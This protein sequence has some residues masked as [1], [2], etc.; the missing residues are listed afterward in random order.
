MNGSEAPAGEATSRRTDADRQFYMCWSSRN[1]DFRRSRSFAM[2]YLQDLQSLAQL[3]RGSAYRNGHKGL[4][5]FLQL[6]HP[7]YTHHRSLFPF[8]NFCKALQVFEPPRHYT[9][10][11]LRPGRTGNPL[12]ARAPWPRPKNSV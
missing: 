3:S 12:A 5:L 8:R 10:A 2:A 6:E 4:L 9:S 7:E 11:T 1:P